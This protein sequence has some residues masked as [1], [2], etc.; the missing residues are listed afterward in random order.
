MERSAA[1]RHGLA[2][3][4][5]PLSSLV[6]WTRNPR[7][8]DAAAVRL[9]QTIDAHGWTTPI[10]VQAWSMRIIGGHTRAKAA[11]IL[12]L[13]SVPCIT[14][15]VDDRQADAIAIAD[16]R[17]GE[18]AEWDQDGL[19][20]LLREL[21]E[22]GA[23]MAAI[24]YQDDELADLL[25]ALDA[26]DSVTTDEQDDAAPDPF[27][28]D[29]DSQPGEVYELGPHRVICGDCRDPETVARLLDGRAVNVAFTSPPY[30]SQRKYDESSGFKPIPPDAYVDWFDAVQAVVRKHLADDGSW[31]VNI[32]EHCEGGQRHLYVKDLT[33]AHVRRWGWMFVDELCWARAGVPGG[34]PN[35]FK[36]G[37]EPV[38]HYSRAADIKFNPIA[39]GHASTAVLDYSPTSTKTAAGLL[40][41]PA[42]GKREGLARPG[43]VLSVESSKGGRG[44]TAEF[45]VALPSFFIRAFSDDGDAIFD[46]FLGSGTTL[47]AAA[48]H[49]RVGYGCEIS[50]HYCD[51]IRRRWTTWAEQAGVDPGPG[52]LR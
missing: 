21:S 34:W 14:L 20:A 16:N 27:E 26:Q 50:A 22:G 43:N 30:A 3:E 45:P 11:A 33:I 25:G 24:G 4:M 18:L 2:V 10:L 46:P 7:D 36:N 13:S 47:I 44:H 35:R 19:G 29:A 28:G 9:A 39:V 37:W 42:D 5:L 31:F 40:S 41:A 8:N 23:D 1:D 32:K 52:A 12:G 38:F 51:V 48:K 49:G 17:L 15:D 6:P